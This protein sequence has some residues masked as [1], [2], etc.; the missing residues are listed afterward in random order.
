MDVSFISLATVLPAVLRCMGAGW[1]GVLLV[2]PQFEAGRAEVRR[3]VVRDPAVHARTVQDCCDWLAERGVAVLGVCDSSLP[4]PAGNREFLVYV[5]APESPAA[6][7][8][9]IDV[10]AAIRHAV[11]Q[12][13]P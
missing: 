1:R 9:P 11:D 2:K 7:E 4:G 8:H 5:A 12:P 3:G 6:R 13:A 10:A